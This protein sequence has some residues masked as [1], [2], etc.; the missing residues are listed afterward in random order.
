M[1]GMVV[2]SYKLE[3]EGYMR[4]QNRGD[5]SKGQKGIVCEMRETVHKT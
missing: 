5:I 4:N 2:I 3:S 1:R